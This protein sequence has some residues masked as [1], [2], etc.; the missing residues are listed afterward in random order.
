VP[1]ER[2]HIV[3]ALEACAGNQTRAAKRLGM[4]RA[5][6]ATKLALHKIPRPRK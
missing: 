2:Q 3:D 5:T 1:D 6:L 4:S